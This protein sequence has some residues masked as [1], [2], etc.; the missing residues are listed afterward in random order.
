LKMTVMAPSSQTAVVRPIA[1]DWPCRFDVTH[2]GNK[3]LLDPYR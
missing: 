3:T 1:P 2:E